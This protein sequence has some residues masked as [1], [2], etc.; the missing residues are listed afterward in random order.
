MSASPTLFQSLFDEFAQKLQSMDAEQ[1]AQNYFKA[2]MKNSLSM[3]YD[4]TLS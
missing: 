3:I 2:C 4:T 1:I